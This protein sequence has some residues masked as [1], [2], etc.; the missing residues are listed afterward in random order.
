[1]NIIDERNIR[2]IKRKMKKKEFDD[3]ITLSVPESGQTVRL[4]DEGMVVDSAGNPW[5]YIMKGT[6]QKYLDNLPDDYEGSINLGHMQF[7]TFPIILGKW[8]KKDLSLVDIGDGRMGLNVNLRLDNDSLLVKELRRMPYEL[9]VSAEF[10]F[11]VNEEYSEMYQLEILDEIFIKDFAIVGEAGNVGSSNITLKGDTKVNVKEL[12]Q[13]LHTEEEPK[14]ITDL[15]NLLDKALSTEEVAEE[16]TEEE[17]EEVEETSEEE[18]TEETEEVSEEAETETEEAEAEEPAEEF[19]LSAIMGIINDLR[20]DNENLRSQLAD[21]Q[22]KLSAKESAEKDFLE[23][24]KGLS[25]SIREEKKPV[26]VKH[27]IGMTN[28]IGEL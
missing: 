4:L 12:L 17:T 16:V 22:A 19:N 13:V 2:T 21:V 8:N 20:A 18:V 5:F 25:V 7:A 3:M 9:G 10:S 28:G 24:F 1:M 6:L 14:D 11:S 15:N 27:Q 26:E 23:K